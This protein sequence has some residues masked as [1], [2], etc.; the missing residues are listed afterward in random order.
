VFVCLPLSS[1]FGLERVCVPLCGF[2][3]C[4]PSVAAVAARLLRRV[5]CVRAQGGFDEADET[6]NEGIRFAHGFATAL[7]RL[8]NG[9]TTAAASHRLCVASR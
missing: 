1:L 7:Q 4:G 3:C 8:C 6:T 5:V 9:F 2:V